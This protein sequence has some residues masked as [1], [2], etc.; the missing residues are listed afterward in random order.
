[1]ALRIP[2]QVVVFDYGDVISTAQSD[3]DRRAMLRTA[4]A[5]ADEFWP[6]YWRHRDNLDHGV[7]T[8]AE[9]W[10]RI[11]TDLGSEFS[12]AQMQRLWATDFRSW[13]S[14]EP[15]TIDLIGE[16]HEGGTRLALLSNAGFDYGDPFRRS[17]IG[18]LFERVFLS[19]EL[20]LIKPDPEI[21]RTVANELGIETPAMVFVDNKSVNVEAATRLGVT[22]HVFTGVGALRT[23][24]EGLAVAG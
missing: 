3:H 7:I 8:T 23:F 13:I 4:Q 22:G 1:M 21:Y 11:G 6:S 5:E 10:R 2:D 9:Y 16:L 24:L 14:A 12:V 15:G 19:A 20:G 18:S 17:P